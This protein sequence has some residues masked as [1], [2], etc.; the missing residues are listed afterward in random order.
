MAHYFPESERHHPP[1]EA[2]KLGICSW[3]CDLSGQSGITGLITFAHFWGPGLVG[4]PEG[5]RFG[6]YRVTF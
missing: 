2:F 1:S 6:G 4:L 3:C 5:R